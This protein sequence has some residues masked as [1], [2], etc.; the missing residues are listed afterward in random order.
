MDQISL[1]E[2]RKRLDK[3]DNL[4]FGLWIQDTSS[5]KTRNLYTSGPFALVFW[6]HASYPHLGKSMLRDPKRTRHSASI[7]LSVGER[8]DRRVIDLKSTAVIGEGREAEERYK[9]AKSRM[10]AFARK[11]F[12]IDPHWR[13]M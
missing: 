4:N 10:T 11:A 6:E 1:L 2:I 7:E 8:P 9:R 12:G 5:F 13:F 3:G